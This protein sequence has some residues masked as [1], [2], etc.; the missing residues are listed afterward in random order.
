MIVPIRREP[1]GLAIVKRSQRSER[2]EAS[3]QR[4]DVDGWLGRQGRG[5]EGLHGLI[6]E[7]GLDVVAELAPFST[8]RSSLTM[9][10]QA[11]A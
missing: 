10:A 6:V 7:G 11:Y 1:E 5:H 9:E 3:E 2:G 4:Q 8:G